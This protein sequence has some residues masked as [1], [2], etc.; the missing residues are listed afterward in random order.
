MHPNPT[1]LLLPSH[2]C[3]IPNN[4]ENKN[5]ME[6]VVCHTIYPFSILPCLQMFITMSLWS[7]SRT[8]VSATLLILEPH[9]D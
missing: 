7:G 9:W 4:K 8:L 1:H 3:N 2:P 5:L 6:A